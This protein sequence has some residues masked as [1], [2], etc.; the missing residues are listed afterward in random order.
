MVCLANAILTILKLNC[1]EPWLA[2]DALRQYLSY[3]FMMVHFLTNENWYRLFNLIL[4]L[5]PTTKISVKSPTFSGAASCI[6]SPCSISEHRV[7]VWLK[8]PCASFAYS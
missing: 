7:M 4:S 8:H 2:K 6:C 5:M 3:W 1:F